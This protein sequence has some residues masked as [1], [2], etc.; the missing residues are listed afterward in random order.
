DQ[1]AL[2]VIDESHRG[3]HL[4]LAASCLA[5]DP[6]LQACLQ[7]MQLCLA[8]GAF[9]SQQQPIVEVARIIHAVLVRD[10]S[11]GECTEFE[12]PMPVSA[13]ARQARHFESQH[14]ACA[15][16]AYLG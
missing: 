2:R 3:P 13:V 7:H 6:T 14:N 1:G 15:P 12:E 16:Y 10:E 8:H 11:G 4:Q 9:E 5:Q